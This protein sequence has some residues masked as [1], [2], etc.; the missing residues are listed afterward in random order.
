MKEELEREDDDGSKREHQGEKY[1]KEKMR[2]E[3]KRD[4]KQ[5]YDEDGN[6]SACRR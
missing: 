5:K 1:D 6:D 2:K 3:E 4:H